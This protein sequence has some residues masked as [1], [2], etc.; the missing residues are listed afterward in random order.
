MATKLERGGEGLGLSGRVTKKIT[1]LRLYES[2]VNLIFYGRGRDVINTVKVKFL[3][4]EFT[5]SRN[6][7][8][9]LPT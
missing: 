5:L 3:R 1:F 2:S 4:K 9:I 8:E 6:F 7:N